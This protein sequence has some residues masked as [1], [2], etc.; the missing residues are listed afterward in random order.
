MIE[1]LAEVHP[2]IHDPQMKQ[3]KAMEYHA[4]PV[5][6]KLDVRKLRSGPHVMDLLLD[7][8]LV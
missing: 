5:E 3:W 2:M 6:L 8:H 7:V 1:K 4:E